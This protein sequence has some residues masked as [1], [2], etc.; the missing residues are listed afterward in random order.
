MP[1]VHVLH[2]DVS[3]EWPLFLL[4]C[5]CSACARGGQVSPPECPSQ[6]LPPAKAP[7]LPL[8]LYLFLF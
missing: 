1:Q 7:L 4:V 5:Q 2:D 3:R 8:S 6:G